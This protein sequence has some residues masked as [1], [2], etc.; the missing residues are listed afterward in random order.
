MSPIATANPGLSRALR[1]PPAFQYIALQPSKAFIYQPLTDPAI[2]FPVILEPLARA[3]NKE[4][5]V[6]HEVSGFPINRDRR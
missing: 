5:P 2:I 1:S 3:V 6:G 4:Y